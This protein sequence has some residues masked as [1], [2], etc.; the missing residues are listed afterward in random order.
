MLV[1]TSLLINLFLIVF[2]LI[3]SFIPICMI[4]SEFTHKPLALCAKKQI[5]KQLETG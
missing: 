2:H 5:M 1:F 4:N 3:K